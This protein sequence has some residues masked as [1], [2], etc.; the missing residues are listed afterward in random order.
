MQKQQG[1]ICFESSK[2]PEGAKRVERTFFAEGE[3]HHVHEPSSLE[4][5]EWYEYEGKTYF[6]VKNSPIRI[7]HNV[8]GIK[9]RGEHRDFEIPVGEYEYE[10][11]NE[12]DYFSEMKRKIVD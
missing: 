4:N 1:D 2:I 9:A 11:V 5:I 3:G 12:Y 8:K 6:K 10:P 7:E